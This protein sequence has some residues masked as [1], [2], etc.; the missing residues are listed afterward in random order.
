MTDET[1]EKLRVI[2]IHRSLT[3]PQ[4]IM[5]C[6]RFLFLMLCMV[7]TLLAG[8]GG[9]M[10]GNL[11]N[12]LIAAALFFGGRGLLSNMAKADARMSDVFRRSVRYRS[13]Y[14]AVSTVGFKNAPKARRW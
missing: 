6:E 3:R 14:P 9:I 1:N 7:V 12:I 13:E 4:L 11:A 10:T 8:P 5:G 2:P